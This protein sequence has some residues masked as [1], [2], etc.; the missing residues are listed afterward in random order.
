MPQVLS[1][2]CSCTSQRADRDLG[3]SCSGGQNSAGVMPY[4]TGSLGVW[5][6][7]DYFGE[8]GGDGVWP[9]VSCDFGNFDIAGLFAHLHMASRRLAAC[10]TAAS[11]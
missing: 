1:E 3:A 9:Y 6:L 5:T 10:F 4:V 2:C 11:C 7:M 8:P